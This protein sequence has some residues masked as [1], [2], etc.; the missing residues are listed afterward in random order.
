M[1]LRGFSKYSSAYELLPVLPGERVLASTGGRMLGAGS[2]L[3]NG[4]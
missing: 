1:G 4:K 3:L 2:A